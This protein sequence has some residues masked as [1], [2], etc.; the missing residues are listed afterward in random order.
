[1]KNLSS[2]DIARII[3]IIIL[4]LAAFVFDR[5]TPYA[6]YTFLRI[7]VMLVSIYAIF[8]YDGIQL[9]Q[10]IFGAL[11]ILYNPIIKIHLPRSTWEIFNIVSIMIF[12]YSFYKDKVKFHK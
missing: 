4:A 3:S 10:W 5:H 12:V 9:F 6:A 8:I 7:V 11:A 1:M 2:F